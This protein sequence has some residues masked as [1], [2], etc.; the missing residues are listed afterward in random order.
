MVGYGPCQDLPALHSCHLAHLDLIVGG[1]WFGGGVE[2][3]MGVTPDYHVQPWYLLGQL[4]VP[5]VPAVDLQCH[6]DQL[7]L[8]QLVLPVSQPDDDV[9]PLRLKPRHLFGHRLQF[10]IDDESARVGHL[11]MRMMEISSEAR[12]N[13]SKVSGVR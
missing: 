4:H 9:H 5:L 1:V 7:L 12:L 6:L 8:G 2:E 10:I 11:N 3:G 13:T